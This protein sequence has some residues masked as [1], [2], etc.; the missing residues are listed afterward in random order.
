[1]IVKWMGVIL[2]IVK[3]VGQSG[4]CEVGGLLWRL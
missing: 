2:V 4:N 3:W 1:M